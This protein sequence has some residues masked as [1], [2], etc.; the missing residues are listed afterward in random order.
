MF[1]LVSES[2]AFVWLELRFSENQNLKLWLLGKSHYKADAQIC[3]K[4]SDFF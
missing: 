1:S 4:H 3:C 2:V